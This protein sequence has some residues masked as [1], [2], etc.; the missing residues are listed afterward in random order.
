MSGKGDMR[1]Q[2]EELG[3]V[4]H[5]LAED[6]MKTSALA[7]I[8][9]INKLAEK[10]ASD[11]LRGPLAE[12]FVQRFHTGSYRDATK[13]D[14]DSEKLATWAF[15]VAERIVKIQEKR[16]ESATAEMRRDYRERQES[17]A[18]AKLRGEKL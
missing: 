8:I 12:H 1:E 13:T 7:P 16:V 15:A 18:I 14:I 9:A 6:M 2:S 4:M 3:N 10:L 17:A 11:F 5:A